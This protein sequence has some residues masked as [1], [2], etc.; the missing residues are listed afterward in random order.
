MKENK[1]V[2]IATLNRGVGH[3]TRCVP[4]IRALLS[5]QYKVTI[6]SDGDALRLLRKEFPSL[7]WVE[8]PTYPSL[9]STHTLTLRKTIREEHEMLKELITRY[10]I[11]AV[12]SDHRLGLYSKLVPS[13]LITHKLHIWDDRATWLSTYIHKRYLRHFTACW[14]PDLQGEDNL[15]GVMSQSLKSLSIPTHYIGA[16]SKMTVTETII[17]YDIIAILSGE[18]PHRAALEQLLLHKLKKFN[19]NVLL[20][21]GITATETKRTRIK[22]IEIV[23][24]LNPSQLARALNKSKYVI[25]RPEYAFIMDLAVLQ[26]KVFFIPTPG[27]REEEYLAQHLKNLKIAPYSSQDAFRVKDLARLKIYTGF[28]KGYRLH[29]LPLLFGLFEG[30]RKLRSHSK[31]A[32]N[33]HFLLVRFNNM[34]NDREAQT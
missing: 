6:A 9:C 32:F 16:L 24:A 21:Q 28:N 5:N 23:N 34:L 4:I 30:K 8:L 31:L 7:A 25:A 33:I 15:S 27:L 20:V 11:D 1:H 10:A 2:L 22:N 13:V 17:D 3:A 14:I 26:K 12:I 29:F 19:G 18:E